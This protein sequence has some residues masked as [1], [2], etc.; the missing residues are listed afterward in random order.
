MK[1]HFKELKFTIIVTTYH[2]FIFI[3]NSKL[4]LKFFQ[5]SITFGY[6][7]F[8]LIIVFL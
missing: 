1:L 3:Y 5:N 7:L 8:D 6:E 2:F 4:D